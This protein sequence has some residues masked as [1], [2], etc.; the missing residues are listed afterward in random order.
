MDEKKKIEQPKDVGVEI[1][2][3]A[4]AKTRPVTPAEMPVEAASQTRPVTPVDEPWASTDNVP[5]YPVIVEDKWG[6]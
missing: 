1:S 4:E 6:A 2:E 5:P 3:H